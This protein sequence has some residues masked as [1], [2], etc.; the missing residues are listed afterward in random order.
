MDVVVAP[1]DRLPAEPRT[2]HPGRDRACDRHREAVPGALFEAEFLEEVGV[3]VEHPQVARV[4]QGEARPDGAHADPIADLHPLHD[5][6]REVDDDVLDA[7][8]LP[9]NHAA[10]SFGL[11]VGHGGDVAYARERGEAAIDGIVR[12]PR[13][14]ARLDVIGFV[15][16][17][18]IADANVERDAADFRQDARDAVGPDVVQRGGEKRGGDLTADDLDDEAVAVGLH[19]SPI[20]QGEATSRSAAKS[21]SGANPQIVHVR[22]RPCTAASPGEVFEGARALVPA[23]RRAGRPRAG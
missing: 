20:P 22:S 16:E 13:A 12:V 7:A 1:H 14:D 2:H 18:R 19:Q 8:V 4:G 3:A 5:L 21:S 10:R 6:D 23:R 15:G 11:A 9:G 17:R